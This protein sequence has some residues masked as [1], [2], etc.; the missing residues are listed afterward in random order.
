M[1]M[2]LAFALGGCDPCEDGSTGFLSLAIGYSDGESGATMRPDFAET[3]FQPVDES[4][5]ASAVFGVDD[6]RPGADLFEYYEVTESGPVKFD[7]RLER[8]VSDETEK[9]SCSIERSSACPFQAFDWY[10]SF[11]FELGRDY[12]LVMRPDE[13][14]GLEFNVQAE[15]EFFHGRDGWVIRLVTAEDVTVTKR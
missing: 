10:A 11:D 4:M 1:V 9:G 15:A 12:A 8:C 2:L 6:P 3:W 14:N 13:G 5:V 7:S